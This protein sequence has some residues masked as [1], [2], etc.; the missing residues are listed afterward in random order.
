MDEV[1]EITAA[2][3]AATAMM[4]KTFNETV[5]GPGQTRT[6]LISVENMMDGFATIYGRIT[7]VVDD[8][9]KRK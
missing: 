5:T 9:L 3:I 6:Y 8:D 1:P 4:V 2:K 7:A